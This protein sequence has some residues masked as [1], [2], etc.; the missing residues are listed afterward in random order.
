MDIVKA[1][2]TII[3]ED[4]AI[5]AMRHYHVSHIAVDKKT[6][7]KLGVAGKIHYIKGIPHFDGVRIVL[8]G[9]NKEFIQ[10]CSK[11]RKDG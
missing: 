11:E 2:I 1:T 6:F 7:A 4:L 8:A 9:V 3:Y 5:L 10:V